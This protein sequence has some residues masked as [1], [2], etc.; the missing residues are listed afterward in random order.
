[1][2]KNGR[3]LRNHFLFQQLP[4]LGLK[5]YMEFRLFLPDHLGI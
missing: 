4:K 2:L 5:I 3:G 1:M